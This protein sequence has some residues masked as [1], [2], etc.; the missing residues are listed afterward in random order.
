[1]TAVRPA[2]A[3]MDRRSQTR[4]VTHL[5]EHACGGTAGDGRHRGWIGYRVGPEETGQGTE[6]CDLATVVQVYGTTEE[7]RGTAAGARLPPPVSS[8]SAHEDVPT[9]KRGSGEALER[10][11]LRARRSHLDRHDRRR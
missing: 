9:D 10:G 6:S 7:I 4:T 8:E 1:M 3:A 2:Y 11:T 5:E